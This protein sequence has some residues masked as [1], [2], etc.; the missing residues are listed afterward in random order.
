MRHG[1]RKGKICIVKFILLWYTPPV[2]S[3][4]SIFV[5]KK[6]RI[7]NLIILLVVLADAGAFLYAKL[8]ANPAAAFKTDYA[9]TQD[10]VTYYTFSGNLEPDSFKIVTATTRGTVKE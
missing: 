10:I 1:T 4:G 5:K 6:H 8:N 7:R 3:K 9:R 2:I